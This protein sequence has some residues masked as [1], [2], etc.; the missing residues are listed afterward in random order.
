MEKRQVLLIQMHPLLGEGLRRIF[1]KLDDVQ[2][3][4]LDC[5]DLPV[6]DAR[7]KGVYPVMVLLAG[8]KEDDRATHLI[9]SMLRLYEDIPIVWVELETNI[10][11]LYTSHSLSANSAE[12]I[13][14][15]REH[16]ANPI[17]IIPLEKKT[18]SGTRR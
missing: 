13:N 2:L 7:L 10:L 4:N 12:L 17:E 6:S 3:V 11:R 1:E 18:R 8:E 5:A 14:A 16:D 9:S 15:I